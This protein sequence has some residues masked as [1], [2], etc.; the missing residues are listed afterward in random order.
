TLAT[1]LFSGPAASDYS[2]AAGNTCTPG[3]VLAASTSCTL[4]VGFNPPAAGTRNA[5]LTITHSAAGSPQT[6]AYLGTATPAPQGRIELSSSALTYADTQLLSTT[7]QKIPVHNG[8]HLALNFSAFTLGGTNAGDFSRSG[9]CTVGT[10]LAINA[11][12]T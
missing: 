12:C 2:L 7:A 8:G 11:D 4:V 9:T 6:V 3:L 1:L 5:T 10:P